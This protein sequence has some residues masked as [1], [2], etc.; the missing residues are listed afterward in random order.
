MGIPLSRW[1]REALAAPNLDVLQHALH[2]L[3]ENTVPY[4]FSALRCAVD[5]VCVLQVEEGGCREDN[6]AP[7]VVAHYNLTV[8]AY[9][10]RKG[11][12]HLWIGGIKKSNVD[13][14]VKLLSAFIDECKAAGAK[15]AAEEE[16]K[17]AETMV[18]FRASVAGYPSVVKCAKIG[19][20]KK[21]V[22]FLQPGLPAEITEHKESD[23]VA[24]F[25]TWDEAHA[26]V[27]AWA[28]TQLAE[29]RRVL[30][31]AQTY[32]G[33]ARGLK[34]GKKVKPM[35]PAL[36]T[37]PCKGENC[38]ATD[39]VSHSAECNTHYKANL[40]S[41][42]AEANAAQSDAAHVVMEEVTAKADP[43]ETVQG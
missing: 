37:E 25:P 28:S 41:L 35:P 43:V 26:W 11:K 38:G 40:E 10:E 30:Q 4:V 33:A 20:T 1:K 8:K 18:T 36:P 7:D 3:T 23:K 17:K 22:T 9:F 32:D 6:P 14:R 13:R 31:L 15:L 42:S 16:A 29:A 12:A 21:Q 5:K 27:K 34:E 39:G 19:E 24:H 2:L